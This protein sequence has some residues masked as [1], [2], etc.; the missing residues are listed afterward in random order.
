[1][2]DRI[3]VMNNGQIEQVGTPDELYTQP[4]NMFVARFIGNPSMNFIRGTLD[5][6][7]GDRVTVT[8]Q[9]NTIELPARGIENEPESSDVSVGVR[10]E[11]L[12]LDRNGAG[13]FDGKIS[14]I[15]RIGD[16]MQATV[17]GPDSTELRAVV[18]ADHS[19]TDEQ[20]TSMWFDAEEAHLFDSKTGDAITRGA[21]T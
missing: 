7:D 3:A 13:Y 5:S 16:R 14:L 8:I 17:D 19:L 10:P 1:M 12:R 9:G 18:P 2:S 21:K 15:E 6:L 11:S 20:T 4:K